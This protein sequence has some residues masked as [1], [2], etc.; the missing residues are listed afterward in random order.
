MFGKV[1]DCPDTVVDMDRR[2]KQM[3]A[4]RNHLSSKDYDEAGMN[5]HND[6]NNPMLLTGEQNCAYELQHTPAT[7]AGC[8]LHRSIMCSEK[9]VYSNFNDNE[10]RI[11]ENA[12]ESLICLESHNRKCTAWPPVTSSCGC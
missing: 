11:W 8:P 5:F 6:K 3:Q 7:V 2:T 9:R 1:R 12:L 4:K 10:Y